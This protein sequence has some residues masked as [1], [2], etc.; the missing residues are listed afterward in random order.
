M[1]AKILY[2]YYEIPELNYS[3]QTTNTTNT[4]YKSQYLILPSMDVQGGIIKAFERH[5]NTLT[6]K[7]KINYGIHGSERQFTVFAEYKCSAKPIS[8]VTTFP[9]YVSSYTTYDM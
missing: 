6:L 5:N 4:I 8:N 7:V 3:S 1:P 2:R 9:C